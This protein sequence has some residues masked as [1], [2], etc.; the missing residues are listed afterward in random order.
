MGCYDMAGMKNN[1][2]T[3]I[4]FLLTNNENNRNWEFDTVNVTIGS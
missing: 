4:D 3:S 1:E 2:K